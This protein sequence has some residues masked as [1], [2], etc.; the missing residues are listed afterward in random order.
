MTRAPATVEKMLT[1][2]EVAKIERVDPETVR[3]WIKAGELVAFSVADRD[4]QPRWR[5][6]PADLRA[7]EERRQAIPPAPVKKRRTAKVDRDF[8]KYSERM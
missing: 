8:I 6:R 7:F 3:K 5:I 1:P 4:G 2:P